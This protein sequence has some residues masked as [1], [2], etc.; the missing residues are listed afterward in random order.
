M[1]APST[2]T[3]SLRIQ[4]T[5]HAPREKVFEAW[6][7][8]EALKSWFC[9][10]GYTVLQTEADA[11]PG[12]SYLIRMVKDGGDEPFQVSGTYKEVS[13]PERL[14]FT[15]RWS[16]R[17][18]MNDTLVTVDLAEEGGATRLTLVHEL[19]DSGE[20]RDEHNAGWGK[21]LDGL[22]AYLG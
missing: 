14:V 18:E 16:H 13:R 10:E 22:T 6:T 9:H 12:G 15:W 20:L 8:A 5:F 2:P 17:P 3:A 4:R 1:A 21:V 19:F 11:R 7:R